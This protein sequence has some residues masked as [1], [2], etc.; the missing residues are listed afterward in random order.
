MLGLPPR[1]PEFDR[2]RE[3]ANLELT[4]AGRS[5]QIGS[6]LETDPQISPGIDIAETVSVS[7][8][9]RQ[10]VLAD[11]LT[12]PLTGKSTTA[13]RI[14]LAGALYMLVGGSVDDT[15]GRWE[16]RF[17]D[18]VASQMRLFTRPVSFNR[19][20][21][22]RTGA[23]LRL[24]QEAST[25]PLASINYWLPELDRAA[26]TTPRPARPT[27]RGTG[28]APATT[29]KVKGAVATG[30]QRQ[31]IDAIL[32]EARRLGASRR[33]MI[34]A[35][36]CATQ[37]SEILPLDHGDAARNDTIGIFQQ[38]PEW[39]LPRY[40]AKGDTAVR[41]FLLGHEANLGG[42]DKTK[43]GWKQWHG[44][45]KNSNGEL[46]KMIATVQRCAS[47]AE[48][49]YA[50]WEPEATR[51][52]DAWLAG[53]GGTLSPDTADSAGGGGTYRFTRGD[54]GSRE[55]SWDA[56]GRWAQ[57]V[58]AH[59][60]A[61]RNVFCW[62]S[63]SELRAGAPA[64]T[65]DGSED[66]L[67]TPPGGYEFSTARA[68]ET[69]QFRIQTG[70]WALLVGAG[71]D[72][73]DHGVLDGRWIVRDT[74]G[75]IVAPDMTVTLSRPVTRAPEPAGD[76]SATRTTAGTGGT[77]SSGGGGR[78]AA[79][80]GFPTAPRGPVTSGF[81]ARSSPGGI[82]ST[83]HDGLD[84]G[85]P[86]GTRVLAANGGKVTVAGPNGGYGTYI[87]IAH[88]GGLVSFYGHLSQIKVRA[89]QT[90]ERGQMIALSGNTGNSTGPHLHFGMHQA[91]VRIDP[92]RYI[93]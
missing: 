50:Q 17:E 83:N 32:G 66:W 68:V 82:G 69:C 63:D 26:A 47:W 38:G 24:L 44:S 67:L 54:Q 18:A 60:W 39:C 33:V 34:A 71:V 87:E 40:T 56:T 59:R 10:G 30:Q 62:V 72:I 91:G 77:T 92:S 42:T 88:S 28:G 86:V 49:Y 61:Q 74:S 15:A 93:H 25:P 70:A 81:G 53:N 13:A 58:G 89:G 27:A 5:W 23:V 12:D 6:M 19:A 31:I 55:S 4:V 57:D 2:A 22:S 14:V 11:V 84:I 21:V 16:L 73:V 29:Y 3:V 43:R 79:S 75:G 8:T 46:W 76:T 80:W 52:V 51:T 35:I 20:T 45:V 37:E 7:V 36:M 9:D 1:A 78:T 64:L 65:V 85:V 90:V 48:K 41:V